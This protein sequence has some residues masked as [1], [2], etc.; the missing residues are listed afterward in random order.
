MIELYEY[1]SVNALLFTIGVAGIFMNCKNIISIFMCLELLLLSV[2]GNFIAFSY[3]GSDLKGHL[4]VLFILTVAAAETAI[5][6]AILVLLFRK[7]KSIYV[8][9]MHELKG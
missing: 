3:Y 5:G 6:L 1:L 4:F 2:S 8:D 7:K 9:S